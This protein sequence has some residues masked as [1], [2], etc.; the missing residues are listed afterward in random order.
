[1][2]GF[3]MDGNNSKKTLNK[4]KPRLNRI[5]PT[6][7]CPSCNSELPKGTKFC[8]SCGNPINENQDDLNESLDEFNTCPNC[9]IKVKPGLTFCTKCGTS[10]KQKTAP[11]TQNI[12]PNCYSDVKSGLEF[13]T[14]CGTKIPDSD[15]VQDGTSDTPKKPKGILDEVDGIIKS[16]SSGSKKSKKSKNERRLI[17]PL[18]IRGVEYENPGFL[19]CDQCGGYY[20]LKSCE[21][22]DD[23]SDKC[24]CGGHLKHLQKFPQP[25]MRRPGSL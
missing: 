9:K 14:K 25:V 20:Q 11:I 23:F 24:D 21:G 3:F 6:I 4:A 17:K 22:P 16:F 1:M 2:K 7:K 18:R 5:N 15:K 8:S 10:L 19:I 13:C 12:C